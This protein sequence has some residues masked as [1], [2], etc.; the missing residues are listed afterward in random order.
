MKTNSVLVVCMGNICRS[1]VGEMLLRQYCPHLT[2]GSAGI[3]AVVGHDMSA[4]SREVALEKQLQVYSHQ[5]KQLTASLCQ[6][7]DLLLV[8]EK[9]HLELVS[10]IAPEARGKTLLFGHWSGRDIP[11]PHR[12]DRSYFLKVHQM[13][14]DAASDWARVL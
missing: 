1:P 7:W 10:R 8:M 4:L 3:A 14:D 11:D 12:K 2:V 6:G 5:A 9:K 13:L